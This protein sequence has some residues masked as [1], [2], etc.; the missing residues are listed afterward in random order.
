M[1]E[2]CKTLKKKIDKLNLEIDLSNLTMRQIQLVQHLVQYH[3]IQQNL[4]S[5]IQKE[6]NLKIR[7][8][9]ELLD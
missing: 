3:E 9:C 6:L 5:R 4:K 8:F 2:A 7:V 1:E